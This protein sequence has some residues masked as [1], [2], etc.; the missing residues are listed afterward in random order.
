MTTVAIRTPI[1]PS[2]TWDYNM[3]NLSYRGRIMAIRA[4]RKG[5]RRALDDCE[6]LMKEV[7]ANKELPQPN[8]PDNMCEDMKD[9]TYGKGWVDDVDV[10]PH[11]VLK[12]LCEDPN[13]CYRD[14]DQKT[15]IRQDAGMEWL[16]KTR[17]LVVLLG[18]LIHVCGGQPG[19]AT[20][21]VDVMFRNKG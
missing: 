3:E 2:M 13:F 1:P 5:T 18:C 10:E 6:A 9:R 4:I 17:R 12:R 20:E 16:L 7:I 8:V 14:H 15:R 21:V 19:R 11:A